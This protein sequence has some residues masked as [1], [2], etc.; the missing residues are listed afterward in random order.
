MF[1][2]EDL[3]AINALYRP[4]PMGSGAH[5]DFVKIREGSKKPAFDKGMKDVTK[6]TAGLYVYQEQV[7]QAMVVGGMSLVTADRVRTAIKKF[8]KKELDSF[9][10]EFIKGYS[11][12]LLKEEL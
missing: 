12:L 2:I 1:F 7:M 6:H 5:E 3:N 9:K 8:D 4:G 11:Q 10:D